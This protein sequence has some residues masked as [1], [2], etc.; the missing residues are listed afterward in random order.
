M[1]DQALLQFLL[2]YGDF[3]NSRAAS[4]YKPVK[5]WEVLRNVLKEFLESYDEMYALINL[6]LFEGTMQHV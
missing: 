2:I 4:C 6:D 3:A 5:G 1:E